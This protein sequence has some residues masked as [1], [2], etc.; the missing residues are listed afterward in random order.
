V[1][2]WCGQWIFAETTLKIAKIQPALST[3]RRIQYTA[4]GQLV[5]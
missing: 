4:S 5:T 1:W 3:A 2:D